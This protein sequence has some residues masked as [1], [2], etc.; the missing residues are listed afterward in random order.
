MKKEIFLK[1]ISII[2]VVI[3]IC[4]MILVHLIQFDGEKHINYLLFAIL[5]VINILF[6]LKIFIDKKPKTNKF[7]VLYV[8]YII[9]S[10]LI[11][12]YNG[13]IYVAPTWP[14]SELMG[15]GIKR[16][17]SDIYGINLDNIYSMFDWYSI[18]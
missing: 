4:C 13:A 3:P 1:I 5:G 11:P 7:I 18:G 15:L 10:I 16:V 12:V 8:I 2:L 17:K 6:M 14:G 9:I